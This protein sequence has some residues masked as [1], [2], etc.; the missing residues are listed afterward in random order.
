MYEHVTCLISDIERG[1]SG[2][3]IEVPLTHALYNPQ[4]IDVN[5]RET[6]EH[7]GLLNNSPYTVHVE[8]LDCKAAVAP[9]T[10]VHRADHHQGGGFMGR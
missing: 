9:L 7:Y 6:L 10:F 8:S 3:D 4:I 5:Y 1:V 2:A